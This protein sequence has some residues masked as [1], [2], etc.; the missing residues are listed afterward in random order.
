MLSSAVLVVAHHGSSWL[1]KSCPTWCLNE[2]ACNSVQHTGRTSGALH[3]QTLLQRTVRAKGT[4]GLGCWSDMKC[5]GAQVGD[6]TKATN[7]SAVSPIL[8]FTMVSPA[9]NSSD[10]PFRY[11]V[12]ADLG[13][14]VYS[15]STVHGLMVSSL[16]P[17]CSATSTTVA[18]DATS[19]SA[20]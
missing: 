1:S 8:N 9:G 10:Y 20:M 15:Y 2:V 17:F 4:A 16:G 19:C 11:G 18:A 14:T 7:E 3:E 12:T 13:Q 5:L 6:G